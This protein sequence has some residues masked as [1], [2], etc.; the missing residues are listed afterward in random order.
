M[1]TFLPQALD[2]YGKTLNKKIIECDP[3]KH[4]RKALNQCMEHCKARVE[5]WA[6][7]NPGNEKSIVKMHS[8]TFAAILRRKG[9][10]FLSRTGGGKIEY[11]WMEDMQVSPAMNY[12]CS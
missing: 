4:K 8:L 12:L 11:Q 3:L 1:L 5:G 2:K 6:L 7:K 10:K 9:G